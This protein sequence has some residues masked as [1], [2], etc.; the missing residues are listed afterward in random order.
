REMGEANDHSRL[1]KN[2]AKRHHFVSQF[3][4][5]GF[6]HPH[7]GKDCVFQMETEGRKAP[8]RV[9]I[10]KAASR[11]RYYAVPDAD[12][13]LSNRNE[14][15]LALVEDEAAYALRRLRDDPHAIKPGDR[16]TIALFLA[17]QMMR[18]P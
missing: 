6:G 3:V 10:A 17:L 13:K 5:R 18:T 4:L 16:A 1:D 14:G 12:G 11:N 7:D 2:T 8:R 9:Q 15:Y